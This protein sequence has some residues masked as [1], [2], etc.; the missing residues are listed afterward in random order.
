MSLGLTSLATAV[1]VVAHFKTEADEAMLA[2]ALDDKGGSRPLLYDG[3][4]GQSGE[5]L[6]D[7]SAQSRRARRVGDDGRR[8]R[9]VDRRRKRR[10]V[11]FLDGGG[12]NGLDDL[13]RL[14]LFRLVSQFL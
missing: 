10:V 6:N 7:D 9:G 4:N 8:R 3:H 12:G 2:L 5:V 1:E 13:D 11:E 14:R